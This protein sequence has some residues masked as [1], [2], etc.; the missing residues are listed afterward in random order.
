MNRTSRRR[1]ATVSL[2]LS[3][4]LIAA[5]CGS[6]DTSGDSGGTAAEGTEASTDTSGNTEGTEAPSTDAAPTPSD[7]PIVI[8]IADEP[9]TLD[10][11]A[12]E[13]GNERAVTDNIY[14]TLVRRNSETNELEPLLAVELPTQVDDTTWEFTIREGISFTNGEPFNAEAAAYSINRVMD[15][16]YNSAQVDF[17]GGITG[18]E[19]VDSTTLRVTTSDLDPVFPARMYRLKMVPPVA[20]DDA[21]FTENP[22][23]TGPY[24]MVEWKRGEEVVLTANPDYWGEAPAITD[25]RIRFI[26][27]S[28]TRVAGLQTGEIDL[29]TLIP[30]EQAGDAPK[31]MSREGIEF[32]V[33][34]LKNYEGVLMDPRIRQAMNYAVDKEAIANDLFSGFA[35]VAACQPLTTAHFGYNDELEAY[36]Y[37]PDRARQLLEEAGYAGETVTLLGATGRW[38]KDAEMSEVVIAYLTDVGFNIEPDIRPFSSYIGEFVKTV[39][40]VQPDVG[41]VSASNELFDASKIESYYL[42]TGG[43]SSYVDTD[44]DA[45]LDAARADP[46]P[47][48]REASFHE[49]LSIGCLDDPVFIFTV[50]LQDIYGAVENLDWAPRSDGSLYIP[51]MSLG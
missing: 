29:A 32:P 34:R 41:F 10:P 50:N 38:L 5:S 22:V 26:P 16:E 17:Y 12:T 8:A 35:S 1:T 3:L 36:P 7:A 6:D 40:D 46:D 15:P 21:A 20:S 43:L 23:G 49:A 47:A 14:E 31:S 39:G 44:V 2:L 13:D 18:A 25:A 42:S 27:Q 45:A 37:D 48:S 11:Q 33:Y 19:A 4:G 9:S 24:S 30:P 28:G 51:E